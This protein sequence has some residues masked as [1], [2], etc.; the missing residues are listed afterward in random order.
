M[1]MT[2]ALLVGLEALL[3]PLYHYYSKHHSDNNS[4]AD[5]A[6]AHLLCIGTQFGRAHVPYACHQ[7]VGPHEHCSSFQAT[8]GLALWLHAPALCTWQ[9]LKTLK[10]S[11]VPATCEMALSSLLKRYTAT[12]TINCTSPSTEALHLTPV[13]ALNPHP[14]PTKARETQ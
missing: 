14:G 2:S 13:R 3:F 10:A 8:D 4:E 1:L 5:A 6:H 9:T 12:H 11:H 7:R